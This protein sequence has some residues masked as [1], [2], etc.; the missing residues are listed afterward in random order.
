MGRGLTRLLTHT[1]C[2]AP[3]LAVLIV[4]PASAQ[5]TPAPAPKAA[6]PPA[7][8]AKPAPRPRAQ[9]PTVPA[10][11]DDDA[12]A[13][14]EIVVSG[15][16]PTYA[17]LPGAVVGDITP[18]L[19]LSPADIQSYG[20]STLTELLDELAPETASGRGRGGEAPVVLLNGRRISG[21]NEIRD[22]PT[23]AILRVDI[24]PEEVAL[25]YGFTA[26]QRVVNIVLRPRFR[27]VTADLRGGGPTDGGQV[28]GQAE[29]DQF[30]VRG[31]NRINLDLKY[32]GSSDLTEAA[33]GLAS[34]TSSQPY[35]VGGNVVAATG[36]GQID[37]A[38]S[39]LAGRPVTVAGV[40]AAAGTRPLTLGDFTGAAN[41]TDIGTV[42]DLSAAT[43][44][45]SANAVVAKA[46]GNGFRST[47]NATLGATS[48][49]SLRGLPSLG[50]VVPTGNPF[51]PF[52][53]PV[54]VDRYLNGFG[55][56]R[57]DANGWTAHLG[58][59]LNR[60]VDKW[61]F[62]LT[63]NYDHGD[64]TTVS[65]VG[66]NPA[67][68]QALLTSGSTTFNPFTAPPASL[69]A[70]LPRNTARSVSDSGNVQAL[71]AGP[72]LQAWAGPLFAS[73]KAGDTQSGF[74]TSSTR[75][76]VTQAIRLSRNDLNGQ[77]NL[78]LPLT[79]TRNKVL[80]WM[81]D[82]SVNANVAV[83]RL[84]GFGALTTL[85]YGMNWKPVTGVTVIVS[86]T[87]DEQAPS[88][89]QLGNPLILTAGARI[90][91]FATGQTVDVTQISGGTRSLIADHRDVFKAGLTWKPVAAW[92]L[93]LTANYTA[94]RID[95][96]IQTFPVDTAQIEAAF[97]DRFLRDSSGAL[98]EVDNRPVNFA[99]SERKQLRWGFN[100]SRPVGKPPPPRPRP[101]GFDAAVAARRQRAANGQAAAPANGVP[102]AP[103][104]GA[105]PP[106]P[107]DGGPAPSGQPRGGDGGGRGG[108]GGGGG[109][110]RGGRGGGG[111]G[112]GF[113]GG[114][115]PGG[116]GQ[117][118]GRFRVALYHTIYFDDRMLVRNGGP[119]L[120]LLHGA[121]AGAS[122]GQP[123]HQLEG[124]LGYTENNLGASLSANWLS[125]TTVQGGSANGAG[126]LT[127]SDLSTVNIRLFAN[128]GAMRTVVQRHP[129][130][131]GT[132]IT[133]NLFNLFDQRIKVTD[134]S[135]RT[136]ISFQPGYIDP[137][138]RVFSLGVRKLFF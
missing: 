28:N 106:P 33:R 135:G 99:W 58:G 5:T 42:R 67:P 27:S 47:L 94:S 79:S 124:Q 64:S 109:G 8:S 81:G 37:P 92:D 78:D 97:P 12:T 89:Q 18:E 101:P 108:G 9:R 87:R 46:L 38:L 126:D 93:T 7:P 34:Q 105:A 63:G 95:N 90:F 11:L 41:S 96:P 55:P 14:S 117:P 129:W 102:P 74:A 13:V 10:D 32:N 111:F 40:P 20:V 72:L 118:Q 85:G 22:I 61:R 4:G 16:K 30:R 70:L 91:D 86:H 24:L 125:G 123:Q 127:F 6:A 59:T 73:F 48:S 130:L 107:A 36:G 56:L 51:S 103:A 133:L 19:M 121:A 21:F 53:S 134:A 114:G 132:R 68:L 44:S 88:I 100:Y 115:P 50:L 49:E 138:G 113:P 54:K 66:V 112:G 26:D 77:M 98:V 29:G 120:D 83:D 82:L 60:D 131:R 110:G 45:L 76:G 52:A 31:D 75:L 136:P 43:Q 69:I 71:A 17:T 84:S 57:Q 3:L 137:S 122:G 65:D 128:A 116:G 1:V 35:A 80:P 25:K 15:A 62:N 119:L 104:D 39:A 23:E 2:A